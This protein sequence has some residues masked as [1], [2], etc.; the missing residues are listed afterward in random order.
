[1]RILWVNVHI[2]SGDIELYEVG[3]CDTPTWTGGIQCIHP[4]FLMLAVF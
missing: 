2:N 1:M 3:V 4:D